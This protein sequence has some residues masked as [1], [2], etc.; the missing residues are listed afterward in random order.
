[1]TLDEARRILEQL[2]GQPVVVIGGA[3]DTDGRFHIDTF[4]FGRVTRVERLKDEDPEAWK[5]WVHQAYGPRFRGALHVNASSLADAQLTTVK[6]DDSRVEIT[7]VPQD[8]DWRLCLHDGPAVTSIYRDTLG[9]R[10]RP[11][12]SVVAPDG[13][14]PPPDDFIPP[15]VAARLA[16]AIATVRDGPDGEGRPT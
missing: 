11:P 16:H 10:R 2:V 1:V 14:V 13:S 3:P 9:E 8:T 5:I 4:F 7:E 15:E 12:L 6:G